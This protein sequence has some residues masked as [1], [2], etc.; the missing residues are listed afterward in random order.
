MTFTSN[1]FNTF[2]KKTTIKQKIFFVNKN[3]GL[4]MKM[5]S[6]KTNSFLHSEMDKEKPKMSTREI[7]LGNFITCTNTLLEEYSLLVIFV[8]YMR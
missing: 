4:H 7:N 6:M 3:P 5:K 1:I 8:T 2:R